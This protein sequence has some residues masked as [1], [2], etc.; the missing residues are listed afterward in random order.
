MNKK[1]S[2]MNHLGLY[3][4]LQKSR[5]HVK[6]LYKEMIS[7]HTHTNKTVYEYYSLLQLI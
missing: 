5:Y 6:Y 7:Q 1:V 3:L 4:I 2:G